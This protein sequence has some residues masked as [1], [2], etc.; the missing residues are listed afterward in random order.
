MINQLLQR[1][2]T[3]PELPFVFL[4]GENSLKNPIDIAQKMYDLFVNIGYEL[5]NKVSACHSNQLDFIP[6]HFLIISS[7]KSPDI[8]EISDIIDKLKSSSASH[9]NITAFLVKQVK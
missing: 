6:R 7:F 4:D 3:P 9:D 8:Q 2:K 1:E 5:A